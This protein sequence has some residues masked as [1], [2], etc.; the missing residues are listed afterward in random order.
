MKHSDASLLSIELSYE[1]PK[2]ITLVI[3]DN[4]SGAEELQSGFGLIGIRERVK[5][6]NG[7]VDVNTSPGVGFTIS[8]R[9]PG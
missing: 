7:S 1:D 5:L 2:F 9:L 8:M 4:G 6:L 3:S